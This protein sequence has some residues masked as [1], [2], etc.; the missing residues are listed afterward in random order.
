MAFMLVILLPAVASPI[1]IFFAS[2]AKDA[3]SAYVLVAV[4]LLLS[5]FS[6][7]A[8]CVKIEFDFDVKGEER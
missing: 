8:N 3:R 4:G 2:K 6:I 7:F 5:A 1:F